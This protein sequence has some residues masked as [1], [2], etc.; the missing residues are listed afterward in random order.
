[1]P[2][3]GAGA[4]TCASGFH[5]A[6]AAG[7]GP[8]GGTCDASSPEITELNEQYFVAP[9]G[10]KVLVF[11]QN[12]APIDGDPRVEPM[13]SADFKLLL[14]NRTL[15]ISTAR[16]RTRQVPLAESWIKHPDR[17]QYKGVVFAPG[18]T[19]PG[20]FNLWQGLGVE[21]KRGSW[22]LMSKHLLYVICGG[23]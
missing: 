5:R 1:R 20:Y 10:R 11:R 7:W 21:P 14:A 4:I 15:P 13:A 3:R 12:A 16:G 19:S 23:D 22:K 18:Q 8:Q 6:K 17:R 2:K 9:Y